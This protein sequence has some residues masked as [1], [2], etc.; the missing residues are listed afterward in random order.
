MLK[1]FEVRNYKNFKNTLIL[2]LSDVSNYQYNSDCISNKMISKGIIYGK[3]AV[4]KTNLGRAIFD[5]HKLLIGL[6]GN[7]RGLY[8]NADSTE[9]VAV[10]K[11]V[12]LIDDHEIT[13]EYSKRSVIGLVNEK[14]TLDSQVL[15]ILDYVQKRF[16]EKRLDIINADTL[17]VNN[18]FKALGELENNPDE[19]I[20]I[21]PFLRYLFYNTA[22]LSDSIIKKLERFIMGMRLNVVNT[23]NNPLM[24]Y[25]R[26]VEYLS[27]K[28]HLDEFQEFLNDAGVDCKLSID[29]L[30]DGS[31][32]LS[33]DYKKKIPFL[34]TASS[35]T[36]AIMNIFFNLKAAS[37]RLSFLYFDE[38]DAFY[39]YEMSDFIVNYFKKYQPNTQ[40]LFTTHNTNLM[41]NQIMRPDCLFI[42]S[43]HGTLT[44]LRDATERELREGHNLEKLY[45]AGEFQKYE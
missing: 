41:N 44:P 24:N 40:V 34:E 35:G 19:D 22:L 8:L 30:T 29:E 9:D 36:K 32:E 39:H 4:G 2:D 6:D 15:Y 13:Y 7:D 3:N 42:L 1:R 5:I 14:L 10:F 38:F 43:S 23:R 25:S 37:R 11:Y 17:Q 20:T 33:F 27:D 16:V 12:F 45:I 26:R 31:K 21:L 28:Q 18:Y